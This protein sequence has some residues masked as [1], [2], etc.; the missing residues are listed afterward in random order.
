MSKAELS[1]RL[2]QLPREMDPPHDL[3]P[4]IAARLVRPAPRRLGPGLG[5][6]LALA[7]SLCLALGLAWWARPQAPAAG[8]QAGLMQSEARALD[9]EYEAALAQLAAAPV[10][11]P[12]EP[13]LVALDQSAAEIRAALDQ[14]P[15]SR[16]LLEQLRRTYARRLALTQR[17]MLG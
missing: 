2:R 6:G 1:W 17:A 7:A 15:E 9:R 5:L 16:L 11:G 3:W 8:L 14:D 12:V 13:G 4:G 10:P